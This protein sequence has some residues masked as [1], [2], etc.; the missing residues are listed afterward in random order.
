MSLKEIIRAR[1]RRRRDLKQ[2]IQGREELVGMYLKVR[3]EEPTPSHPK[4]ETP[5]PARGARRLKLYVNE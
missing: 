5:L 3:Q 1:N 2:A 4:Q